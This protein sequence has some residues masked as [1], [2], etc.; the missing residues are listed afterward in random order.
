MSDITYASS[1]RFHQASTGYQVS[2]IRERERESNVP[3]SMTSHPQ[4]RIRGCG[5]SSSSSSSSSASESGICPAPERTRWFGVVSTP[6]VETCACTRT[7]TRPCPCSSPQE[8]ETASVSAKARKRDRCV[9]RCIFFVFVF[10][11]VFCFDWRW[12]GSVGRCVEGGVSRFPSPFLSLSLFNVHAE[13]LFPC[14]Q[15]DRQAQ[16]LDLRLKLAPNAL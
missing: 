8:S 11:V 1:I 2:G 3:V 4:R 15:T 12:V 5:V 13:S 7:C 10:A 9:E 14:K 6:G 16:E